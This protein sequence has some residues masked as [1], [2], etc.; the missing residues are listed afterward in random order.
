[1]KNI[2]KKS[3]PSYVRAFSLLVDILWVFSIVVLFLT[4]SIGVLS[5]ISGS[6]GGGDNAEKWG[7]F[8]SSVLNSVIF[9]MIIFYLRR[10]IGSIKE[11]SPFK[12]TNVQSIKRIAYL[13]FLLIPIEIISQWLMSGFEKMFSTSGFV[14][15]VWGNFFKL[16]FV[17][18][19]ILVIGKV[20][21]SG[22]SLQKEKELTI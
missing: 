12:N 9:V 4:I 11:K 8:V 13:V 17:G 5:F 10:I 16:I 2:E 19:G 14:N 18:L 15:L 20:F 21:E 1:M 22:L 6:A 7:I 3:Q